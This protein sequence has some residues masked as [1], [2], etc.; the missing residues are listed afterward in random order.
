MLKLAKCEI[1]G[2][3]SNEFFDSY[4]LSES[5]LFV[6]PTKLLIKTCGTTA[7]LRIIQFLLEI[8]ENQNLEKSFVC[9]SRKNFVFPD[10]QPSP[11][12]SFEEEVS[13]LNKF[14][15]GNGYVLGP[16]KSDHWYMYLADY[17]NS[18]F[19][20]K[21]KPEI[22]LE[23]LMHD[24]SPSVAKQFYKSKNFVSSKKVTKDAGIDKLLPGTTIDDFQFDPCGY[25]MNGL[26][27]DALSTIHITPEPHCSYISYETNISK[28]DL[29]SLGK[30][31]NDLIFDVIKC[32]EPGRFQ[33][34]LFADDHALD[35]TN[36]FTELNF[37]S[38]KEFKATSTTFYEF[39]GGYNLTL[40]TFNR[41]EFKKNLDIIIT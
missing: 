37:N 11:H 39:E 18:E 35:E 28:K 7:L 17:Q 6:Y 38:L 15:D 1:V 41:R 22:T 5:S 16:L 34:T 36:S 2:E 25:S 24:I 29:L 26:L 9:Y 40:A 8:A 10:V 20:L 19:T 3:T 21:Q 14:F 30:T 31:Y 4:V 13:Y 27:G 32:F 12:T 33:I 23:I